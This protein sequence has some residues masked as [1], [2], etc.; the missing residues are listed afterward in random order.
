[1]LVTDHDPTLLDFLS[2]NK[3]AF[4]ILRTLDQLGS[5][6]SPGWIKVPDIQK[7]LRKLKEYD[8]P[9]LRATVHYYCKRLYEQYGAIDRYKGQGKNVRT[10]FYRTTDKGEAHLRKMQLDREAEVKCREK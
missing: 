5:K 9:N 3:I 8:K 1:M 7:E 6:K 2:E 4:E 10:V